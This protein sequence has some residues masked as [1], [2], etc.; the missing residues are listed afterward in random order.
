[1]GKRVNFSGRTVIS[2][3]PSLSM[4]QLRVPIKIANNLTF[5]EIVT[6]Y[7]IEYLS[8]LV[9][10]GTDIYP[11]ANYVIPANEEL[12]PIYLKY[13]K[14]KVNLQYGDTVERH[15]IDGDIILF[16]RQPTLHKLSMMAHR[17]QVVRNPLINTFGFSLCNTKPY[18]ADFDGDEMNGFLPQT[19]LQLN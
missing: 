13:A 11:G 9:K 7:N 12:P 14:E 19:P 6:P 8:G 5:P 2:P 1:M 17:V 16:N 4:N 3:D 10:N 18:N 15:I